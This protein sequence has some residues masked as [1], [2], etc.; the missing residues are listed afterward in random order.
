MTDT[1]LV[2]TPLAD[3]LLELGRPDSAYSAAVNRYLASHLAAT[4]GATRA[5]GDLMIGLLSR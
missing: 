4:G 5:V 2:D 3:R 1:P